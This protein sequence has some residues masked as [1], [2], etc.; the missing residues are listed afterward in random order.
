MIIYTPVNAEAPMEENGT[1]CNFIRATVAQLWLIFF[2]SVSKKDKEWFLLYYYTFS[3]PI[4]LL[5]IAN[6]SIIL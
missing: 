1:Y 3:I 4:L 5:Q 6:F 2:N